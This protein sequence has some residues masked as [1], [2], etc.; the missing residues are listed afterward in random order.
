MKAHRMNVFTIGF[1][2]RTAAD[3]FGVLR[4]AGI[5]RLLD[6]RLNNSSQLAGFTKASDLPFFLKEICDAEYQHEPLLAP[7]QEMLDG[8][9]K[10]KGSWEE[11]ERK[12]LQLMAER[13]IEG[14]IDRSLFT[15]PTAL[16]CSETTAEHCHRRLVLEYLQ[17]KWGGLTMVHL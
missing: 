1:T 15:T 2:K 4:R 3:F 9:K 11:Y 13:G 10:A 8:Y 7:T 17:E 6:V 14:K 16:L 12:F 5:R